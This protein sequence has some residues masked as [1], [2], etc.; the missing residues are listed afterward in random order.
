MHMFTY[1]HIHVYNLWCLNMS[2]SISVSDKEIGVGEVVIVVTYIFCK[3]LTI[4]DLTRALVLRRVTIT[5]I[6]QYQRPFPSELMFDYQTYCIFFF[7]CKIIWLRFFQCKWNITP[8]EIEARMKSVDKFHFCY[9]IRVCASYRF[10]KNGPGLSPLLFNIW[11][12]PSTKKL[13]N[14][15]LWI[16]LT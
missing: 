13:N 14:L 6:N 16:H 4:I 1:V 5:T 7:W 12:V 2:Y 11:H 3:G 15:S 9:N 8:Q 10:L